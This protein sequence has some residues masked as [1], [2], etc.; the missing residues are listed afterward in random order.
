MTTRNNQPH[1]RL[2]W[3]HSLHCTRIESFRMKLRHLSVTLMLFVVSVCLAQQLHSCMSSV[4]TDMQL[5]L[6]L[7][8][9]AAAP[10]QPVA[11]VSEKQVNWDPRRTAIIVC[12]MWDQHWCKSAASRV[13]ELAGPMNQHALSPS[14]LE[15]VVHGSCQFLHRVLQEYQAAPA[16]EGS[17]ISENTCTPSHNGTLGDCLELA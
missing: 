10:G 3:E 2:V 6:T 1:V 12:D 8:S 9:R 14:S 4:E 7:R 16:S 17:T 13:N 5:T 15:H 11:P